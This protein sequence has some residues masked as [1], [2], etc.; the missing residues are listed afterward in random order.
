M[1]R[2]MKQLATFPLRDGD[3]GDS[4]T[5]EIEDSHGGVQRASTMDTVRQATQTF[6]D[7]LDRI[8][9]A[10]AAI[11]GRLRS[12][13]DPPDQVGVEF[14]VKLSAEAGAFIASASSEANFKVTLSWKR[15]EKGNN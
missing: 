7:A 1:R 9:P 2:I 15:N 3:N 11:I 5:V 8:R 10:A 4:I 13:A 12:L 6:E 14:G